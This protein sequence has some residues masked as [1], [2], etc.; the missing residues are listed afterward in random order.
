[1]EGPIL[2]RPQN[3]P[4]KI[5]TR[6]GFDCDYFSF[7]V[8]EMECQKKPYIY[9]KCLETS[10]KTFSMSLLLSTSLVLPKLRKCSMMGFV[11]L[12]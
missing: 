6:L 12:S 7:R 4:F 2:S 1:M 3:A 10:A 5:L 9:S 8:S 11:W